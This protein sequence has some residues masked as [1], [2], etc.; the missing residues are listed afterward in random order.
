MGA[1]TDYHIAHLGTYALRGAAVVFIEAT[2]VQPTGRV[3]LNCPGLWC[4]EQI[5]GVR[6]VVDFV[7]NYAGGLV[8]VQLNRGTEGECYAAVDGGQV[9]WEEECEG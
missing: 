4:D 7:H 1:L 9:V 2:A 6:R 5:E 3:T 8:G